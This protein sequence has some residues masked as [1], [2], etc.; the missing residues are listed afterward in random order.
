[1]CLRHLPLLLLLLLLSTDDLGP[2]AWRSEGTFHTFFSMQWL[3][4]QGCVN[5]RSR[6]GRSAEPLSHSGS[7]CADVP[8]LHVALPLEV[9]LP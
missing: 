5:M 9:G 4:R 1:M 8:S 2:H 6:S 3:R 7:R